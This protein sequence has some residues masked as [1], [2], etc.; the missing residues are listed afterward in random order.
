[1]KV[2]TFNCWAMPAS[3]AKDQ[4]RRVS[5]IAERLSA[6]E[7]D[8]VGLQE[9]WDTDSQVEIA[10]G[11]DRG[12]LK[13]SHYFKNGISGS[14]NMILSRY[15]IVACDFHAYT[16][17]GRPQRVLRD[18]YYGSKGVGM[19]RISGPSGVFDFYVTHLISHY[20]PQDEYKA[21]RV[22]QVFELIQF[23]KRT[24]KSDFL[25]VAGD[26]N[27]TPESL[28]YSMLTG[29]GTLKDA[30]REVRSDA[31]YTS[32]CDDTGGPTQRIDYIF[33]RP[34]GERSWTLQD[35][36]LSMTFMKDSTRTFSD[37]FGVSAT[38]TSDPEEAAKSLNPVSSEPNRLILKKAIEVIDQ[39]IADARNREFRHCLKAGGALAV[40]PAGRFSAEY[41]KKSGYSPS[42]C[43]MLGIL[44]TYF[45]PLIS[46]VQ[47]TL[48]LFFVPGELDAL[49]TVRDAMTRA[50][51]EEGTGKSYIRQAW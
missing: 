44:S 9:V 17:N 21:H 11:A 18:D 27:A 13:Y 14:G 22:A 39:G 50:L 15:P 20:D 7:F 30:Y 5:A 12:G 43:R 41:L 25:V 26:L 46:L 38:F 4:S 31:G 3:F 19:A 45:M 40:V 48:G 35:C 23:I 24:N 42:F 29:L 32:T 34:A 49:K 51:G 33:H 37:H 8:V 47:L 2:L 36:R 10:R 1:M 28:E 16:I 6:G